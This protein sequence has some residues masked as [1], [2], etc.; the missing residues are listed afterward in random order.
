[1]SVDHIATSR[2]NI[3]KNIY[4][5]QLNAGAQLNEKIKAILFPPKAIK[6]FCNYVA[7]T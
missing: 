4:E 2:S 5:V 3:E 6:I 1:V 7:V